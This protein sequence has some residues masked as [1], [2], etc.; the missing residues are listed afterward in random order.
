MEKAILHSDLNIFY[1][2][3]S[4]PMVSNKGEMSAERCS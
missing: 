2:D 3:I 4:E 1:A